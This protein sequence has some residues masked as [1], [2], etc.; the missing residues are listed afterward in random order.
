VPPL[1]LAAGGRTCLN[2]IQKTVHWGSA[3]GTLGGAT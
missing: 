3:H 2:L 1:Q